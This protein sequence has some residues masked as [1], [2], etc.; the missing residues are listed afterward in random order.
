MA[1]N[2]NSKGSKK[3]PSVPA[4]PQ[5]KAPYQPTADLP[6]LYPVHDGSYGVNTLINLDSAKKKGK[7]TKP[8][9]A[10]EDAEDKKFKKQV[11]KG[12]KQYGMESDLKKAVNQSKKAAENLPQG[13]GANTASD[14]SPQ[15]GLPGTSQNPSNPGVSSPSEGGPPGGG[16][17]PGGGPPSG[18]PPG[19][20]PP[21]GG[22]SSGGPSSG[23]PSSGGWTWK[24]GPHPLSKHNWGAPGPGPLGPGDTND[25]GWSY[26]KPLNP[27]IPKYVG[28]IFYGDNY[29]RPDNYDPAELESSDPHPF[30]GDTLADH[31]DHAPFYGIP[32]GLGDSTPMAPF[33][34]DSSRS[35]SYESGLYGDASFQASSM[36]PPPLPIQPSQTAPV[37]PNTGGYV[38]APATFGKPNPP[39]NPASGAYNIAHYPSPEASFSGNGT[40]GS[41]SSEKTGYVSNQTL[42]TNTSATSNQSSLTGNKGTTKSKPLATGKKTSKKG[43]PVASGGISANTINHNGLNNDNSH[44]SSTWRQMLTRIPRVIKRLMLSDFIISILQLILVFLIILV[45]V[46]ASI[47]L[48]HHLA[49]M[50]TDGPSSS[51]PSFPGSGLSLPG[52]G[53]IWNKLPSFGRPSSIFSDRS[54]FWESD[55]PWTED[56]KKSGGKPGSLIKELKNS[57]PEQVYVERGKNGKLRISEDFWHAL[58]DQI[59]A[60]DLILTLEEA[61]GRP[62]TIS[63]KH[64][65][66]VKSR[67]EENGFSPSSPCKDS[68]GKPC[69]MAKDVDQIVQNK[70]S[71]S[72]ENWIKQN[73][74]SIKQAGGDAITK[75][76]F[77]KL[78]KSEAETYSKEIRVELDGLDGRIKGLVSELSKLQAAPTSPGG[79]TQQEVKALVDAAVS[80]AINSA[81]LDA[82]ANGRIRGHASDMVFNQVNFFSPGSG[83]VIDPHL[84]SRAWEAPKSPFKS[85]GWY[86]KDGYKPQPR[87]IVLE[88]WSQEGEC[89]CAGPDLKGYGQ[90]T[91]N[92]SVLLSRSIIPQHLVVEHILSDSTLDPGAMPK[93]IELWA[94]FEELNLRREIQGWSMGEYPEAAREKLLD[95]SWVKIGHFTYLNKNHGDGVQVFK[96][97]DV[98]SKMRAITSQVV[99]RALNN[100]GADHT[101]F[102]RLKLYGEVVDKPLVS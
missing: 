34:P 42:A 64:W 94:A 28:P 50:S 16:E 66:A 40:V 91:N 83:A 9:F 52:L 33:R 54:K 30:V 45:G 43:I 38:A 21:G 93:D 60:D 47:S 12:G 84:T 3:G 24:D 15:Q 97:S 31:S 39:I 89:F 4:T 25:K 17:P 2:T 61:K 65:R 76:E 6:G 51:T 46:W 71:Q 36:P 58:R 102:Y 78:F 29:D 8:G 95:E 18:G 74:H 72:W 49:S 55:S 32:Q 48:V 5:M 69:V 77:I 11:K 86:H 19:G 14:P 53:G 81:K 99:V 13:S 63:D 101:C 73:E 44:G 82:V 92:I 96:I 85:K 67:M 35:F 10:N 1:P 70:L 79:M 37:N 23:G 68:T 20:G 41:S 56:S 80:K 75:D 62:P 59:M 22:P 57:L 7:K 90:G 88:P 27:H 87:A 98:L 100:Y 26:N